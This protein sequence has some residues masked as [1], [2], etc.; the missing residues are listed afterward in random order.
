M[1]SME[2]IEVGSLFWGGSNPQAGVA[3]NEEG[4]VTQMFPLTRV[5]GKFTE[6]PAATGHE[7]RSPGHAYAQPEKWRA[8]GRRKASP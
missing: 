5:P 3:Q 8:A 4:G 2:T 1:I 6:A 7:V